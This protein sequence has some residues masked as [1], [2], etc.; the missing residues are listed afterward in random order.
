MRTRTSTESPERIQERERLRMRGDHKTMIDS[1]HLWPHR[2]GLAL[3]KSNAKFED[4]PRSGSWG[5]V[6]TQFP[7][8]V[9]CDLMPL[10]NMLGVML[11]LEFGAMPD[12]VP[13]IR[14][15]STD[16]MLAAG[17]EVD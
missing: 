12:D 10:Y 15:E 5:F 4:K 1:P 2:Y 13:V 16:A 8:V 11:Q 17:W 6:T 7:N 3:K 14:Y 9:V